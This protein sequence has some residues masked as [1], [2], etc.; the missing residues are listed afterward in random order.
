MKYIK[1]FEGIQ[2]PKLKRYLLWRAHPLSKIYHLIEIKGVGYDGVRAVFKY[3]FQDNNLIKYDNENINEFP[4]EEFLDE[5]IIKQSNN[6]NE[7]Y[8]DL[9]RISDQNKYNL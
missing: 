8:D 4:L 9:E 1:T 6:F 7:I 5:N 3:I 2:L